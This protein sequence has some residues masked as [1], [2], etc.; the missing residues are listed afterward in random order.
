MSLFRRLLTN[1][2]HISQQEA[3]HIHLKSVINIYSNLIYESFMK[4]SLV[5]FKYIVANNDKFC[6]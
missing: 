3:M 4:N 6:K 2:Q 1:Q 5:K